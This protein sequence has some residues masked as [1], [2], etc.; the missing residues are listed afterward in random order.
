[1][2]NSKGQNRQSA[3]RLLRQ[4]TRSRGPGLLHDKFGIVATEDLE[5]VRT[6]HVFMPS[7]ETMCPFTLFTQ[8]KMLPSCAGDGNTE[9][10]PSPRVPGYEVDF[11]AVIIPF[12]IQGVQMPSPASCA[13]AALHFW[14]RY[15]L[16][17]AWDHWREHHPITTP[18]NTARCD[19][20]GPLRTV[21]FPVTQVS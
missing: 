2:L 19:P 3:L 20:L 7:V 11:L 10:V 12:T 16:P 6:V 1:M 21:R 15:P 9:P 14:T 5:L 4:Y 18:T 8:A 17:R 13:S